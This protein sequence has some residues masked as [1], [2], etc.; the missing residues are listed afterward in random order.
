[1]LAA[2][3]LAAG[4]FIAAGAAS[5]SE[6]ASGTISA[7]PL[8]GGNFQ[9]NIALTN[10]STDGSDIGTF[11]FSWIAVPDVDFMEVIPTNFVGPTNWSVSDTHNLGAPDGYALEFTANAPGRGGT[12]PR[13]APGN[14]DQFS[15]DSTE[16]LSQLLGNSTIAPNDP[17]TTSFVYLGPPFGDAGFQF[18]LTPASVP[19]PVSASVIAFGGAALLMRRRRA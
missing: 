8:G 5:A 12:D 10:T 17:E 14:T 9:Y 1:M 4:V 16:P 6:T 11:W 18:T 7:T 15:F 13:L 3:V 2:G 19:E